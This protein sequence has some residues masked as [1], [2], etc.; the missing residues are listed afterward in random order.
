MII[1]I[2]VKIQ[3]QKHKTIINRNLLTQNMVFSQLKSKLL[4]NKSTNMWCVIH[5]HLM[6]F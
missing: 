4:K 5:E 3:R 1:H 2:Q 6:R